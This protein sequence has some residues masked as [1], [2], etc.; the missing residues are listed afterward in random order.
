MAQGAS[1]GR[2]I[3]LAVEAAQPLLQLCGA[4]LGCQRMCRVSTNDGIFELT[5]RL[6][7]KTSR[8]QCCVPHLPLR[9]KPQ[10]RALRT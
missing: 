5:R 7:V 8:S 1:L 2:R 4:S 6:I 9:V 3:D 10:G